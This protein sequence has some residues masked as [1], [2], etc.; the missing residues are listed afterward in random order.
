[1]FAPPRGYVP[2]PSAVE[3][4]RLWMPG[5]EE[6]PA[7]AQ[8]STACPQCGAPTA[9]DPAKGGLSCGSCGHV[10]RIEARAVGQVDRREFTL[11]AVAAVAHGWGAPTSELAC[12]ACG[13]VVASAAETL[14]ATCP[15][16]G[17]HEV[18]RRD[19]AADVLRPEIVLPFRLAPANVP[20][21][22]AAWLG[23]TSWLHPAGLSSVAKV[24][25]FTALYL[26]FW[27][28]RADL[29]ADWSASAG[30]NKVEVIDV[31]D[32]SVPVPMVEWEAVSGKAV[33]AGAEVVWPAT[34]KLPAPILARVEPFDLAES[35]PFEPR[36]LAGWTAAAFDVGLVDAWDRAR[37]KVRDKVR[38][39]AYAGALAKADYVV[40]WQM[41][42]DF[43]D[44]T[45]QYGLVPLY[46]ATYRAGGRT[47]HV[48]VNGRSGA[49]GGSRPV[50]W[51]KV[52]L[53]SLAYLL[54]GVAWV[55]CVG[56]PLTPVLLGF[57]LM[58]W[59]GCRLLKWGWRK[60]KDLEDQAL[61]AEGLR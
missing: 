30:H 54:P 57:F 33:V 23:E 16:C 38:A 52:W 3:G 17:S 24:D 7:E 14:S 19:G 35:V 9:F 56:V 36:I 29:D 42:V 39:D 51:W 55:S 43:A 15:F 20:E 8:T 48:V 22:V 47:W 6:V 27:L 40:S 12:R 25:R 11:E 5:P 34:D 44:E 28:F 53:W 49:V 46:V 32:A 61:R 58:M 37:A 4:I 31:G 1:M 50:L 13:G 10:V 41:E 21:R 2:A 18:R 60:H 59:P 45:W 26:P